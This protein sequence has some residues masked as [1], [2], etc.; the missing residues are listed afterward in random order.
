M[1]TISAEKAIKIMRALKGLQGS[2][3]KL[4]HLT[5][6]RTKKETNGLRLVE[7]CRLRKALPNEAFSTNIDHYLTY[8]DLDQ[9]HTD[10]VKGDARQC[11]K[12]LIRQVAFPP[13]Y[14]WVK[15]SWFTK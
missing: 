11:F 5:Y 13:G 4:M 7:R 6:N 14:K 10:T 1:E 3:F 9:T 15:V 8:S 2:T 12:K